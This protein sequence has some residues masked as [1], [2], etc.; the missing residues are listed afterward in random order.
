[1]TAPSPSADPRPGR[2]L[3]ITATAAERDAVLADLGGARLYPVGPYEALR[4]LTGVGEV[5][6]LAGGA[7]PAAAATATTSG[8]LVLGGIDLVVSM[9]VAGGFAAADVAVGDALVATRVVAADLG[10]AD[11]ADFLPLEQVVVGTPSVLDLP[12][13]HTSLLSDRLTAAG[14]PTTAGTVLTVSTVTGS[15][16]RARQLWAAHTPVGEAMEG[17]GVALAASTHGIP[18]L[19]VRT[20][21]NLV[22]PRDRGSWDLP[23][24]L[25]ALTATAA[26][27]AAAPL[28]R[29]GAPA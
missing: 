1:M 25:W 11:G 12:P 29:V 16:D 5:L 24:A 15:A 20:V 27:L 13:E 22:G 6:V 4:A 23:A 8:L 28:P 21:S 17:Y 19:E 26:A 18:V 2:V 3:V 9:G 7:G 14:L 10:A